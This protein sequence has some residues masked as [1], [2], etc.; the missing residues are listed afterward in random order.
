MPKRA[1]AGPTKVV[2]AEHSDNETKP[3]DREDFA[4][5]EPSLAELLGTPSVLP[6]GEL[7]AA[8]AKS[9]ARAEAP[10]DPP[11]SAQA[12]YRAESI[13]QF[14]D[15]AELIANGRQVRDSVF[16]SDAAKRIAA[17]RAALG[18]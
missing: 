6:P 16:L 14:N 3:T 2:S 7:K 12:I 17:L 8:F 5:A 1:A 11:A 13:R 4:A 10:A 18:L 15:L 9:E